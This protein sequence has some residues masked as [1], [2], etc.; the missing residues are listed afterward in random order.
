LNSPWED[1]RFAETSLAH[2][3]AKFLP[4][5]AQEVDFLVQTLGVHPGESI[6]D[7]GCGAG[8]HAIALASRG[9]AVLGVDISPW[10]LGVARRRAAQAGAQVRFVQ[11]SVADLPTLL[12]REGLFDGAIAIGESGLGVL[13]G[14]QKD[15]AFLK[16]VRAK[17]KHG[18]KLILTTLNGLRRYRKWEEGDDRF[19]YV[20]GIQHWRTPAE[21]EGGAAE[22]G[23]TAVYPLGNSDFI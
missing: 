1:K 16:A 13:G 19:D 2:L 22:G 23:R 4:G 14:W 21:W 7:L 11:G 8:R 10:L 5:T 20:T 15:L 3:D 17:L 12:A 9:Y 6:L 18:R